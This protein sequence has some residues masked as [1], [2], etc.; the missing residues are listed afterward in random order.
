ME[1]ATPVEGVS[2][3][4]VAEIPGEEMEYHRAA[5]GTRA[6]GA[7]QESPPVAIPVGREGILEVALEKHLQAE[8]S[9]Q[10]MTCWS[11]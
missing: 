6:S 8:G 7:H 2:P 3:V 4:E 9:L 10:A 5:A 1:G 11:V